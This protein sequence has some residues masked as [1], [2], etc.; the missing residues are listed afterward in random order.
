MVLVLSP[1]TIRSKDA[2]RGP[3]SP[4]TLGRACLGA[5]E[6]E[7]L[8]GLTKWE[9][10]SHPLH[11]ERSS[12]IREECMTFGEGGNH[13]CRIKCKE[14]TFPAA[15][16]WK[17]QENRII[18]ASATHRKEGGRK[19]ERKRKGVG[20]TKHKIQPHGLLSREA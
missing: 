14:A 2:G 16:M 4:I 5:S 12:N 20:G 3:P 7:Y 15:L 10:D 9:S 19:G 17:G 18:L 8:L 13:N 6:E 1:T 11:G